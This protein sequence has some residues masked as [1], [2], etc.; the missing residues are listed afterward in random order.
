MKQ[1]DIFNID[2]KETER[3]ADGSILLTRTME[4]TEV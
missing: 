3:L 4:K 2:N 1:M